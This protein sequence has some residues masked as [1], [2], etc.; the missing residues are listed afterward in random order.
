MARNS[1]PSGVKKTVFRKPSKLPRRRNA[2]QDDDQNGA[3]LVHPDPEDEAR[4]TKA[5]QPISRFR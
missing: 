1:Q 5:I 2:L 4:L 3:E